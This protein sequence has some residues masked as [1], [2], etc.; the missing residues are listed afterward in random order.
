MEMAA[1]VGEKSYE[2]IEAAP[3]VQAVEGAA[4]SGVE[5]FGAGGAGMLLQFGGSRLE[6]MTGTRVDARR[7]DVHLDR[8]ALRGAVE[9]AEGARVHRVHVEQGRELTLEFDGGLTLAVS[10][11][12]EER[13]GPEAAAYYDASWRYEAY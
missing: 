9:A 7:G 5:F 2:N 6:I 4:L 12:A 13:Q 8:T 1:R 11:R 10:L 3:A